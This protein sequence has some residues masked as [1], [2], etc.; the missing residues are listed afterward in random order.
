MGIAAG[1]ALREIRQSYE[2]NIGRKWRSAG[3]RQRAIKTKRPP[4]R[5]QGD[6]DRHCQGGRL[7]TERS[8]LRPQQ[9]ARH[10]PVPADPR[11]GDRGRPSARLCR[12]GACHA[13]RAPLAFEA[14]WHHRFCRRPARDEPGGRRCDRGRAPG[15]VERW[16]RPARRA[17]HERSRHGTESD[18]GAQQ[19]RHLGAHLH[20]D[21]HP[22]GGGAGL[23]LRSQ[24]PDRSSELLRPIMP[25][26]PLFQAR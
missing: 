4:S 14:R 5:Q 2:K 12:A 3:R 23:S 16:K 11:E 17:D 8:I 24:Y 10:A 26:P 19:Q 7:F 20:D 9:Y 1:F 15:V 6:D 13:A 22:R 21:I 25:F 18:Q